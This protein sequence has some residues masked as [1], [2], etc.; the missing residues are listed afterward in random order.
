MAV[1]LL[2]N[3]TAFLVYS[4]F[5]VHAVSLSR[6]GIRNRLFAFSQFLMGLWSLAYTVMYS[7]QDHETAYVWYDL[8]A[9]G[10]VF[11]P[12]V[13]LHFYFHLAESVS[14]K[15]KNVVLVCF[16]SAAVAFIWKELTG[17][18]LLEELIY[19]DL[20][21]S[22]K[23]KEP[24]VWFISFV[25]FAFLMTITMI[26]I[27]ILNIRK[28]ERQFEKR[29]SLYVVWTMIISVLLIYIMNVLLPVIQ[30][31]E[32]LPALGSALTVMPSAITYIVL[33]KYGDLTLTP[34]M[35]IDRIMNK[36]SDG[37]ILT[38]DRNTIRFA[39]KSI[40]GMSGRKLIGSPVDT[41]LLAG[42][43]SDF[44]RRVKFQTNLSK[45]L[46]PVEIEAEP[47]YNSWKDYL[48]SV[49]TIKDIS[50]LI[51]LQEEIKNRK[52]FQHRLEATMKD[53]VHANRTRA[54]FFSRI[55]HDMRTPLNAI[56]GA[57]EMLDQSPDE[58]ARESFL[59][60]LR[61]ASK[62]LIGLIDNMLDIHRFETKNYELSYQ[63][64]EPASVI[65]DVLTIA[66]VEAER[67]NLRLN[68]RIDV[69]ELLLGDER[70]VRQILMNLLMN[71]VKFTEKGSVDLTVNYENGTLH[72]TV[73]D[74]GLGIPESML[75]E[76]YNPFTQADAS[77]TRKYGG[78]G[79][80]LAIVKEFTDRLKGSVDCRSK[81]GEF[82]TFHITLPFRTADPDQRIQETRS[83]I[84][85]QPCKVLLAEDSEDNQM[86]VSAFLKDQPVNITIAAN[87]Q[88]ALDRVNEQNFDL[89]L[90]DIQMPVMDGVMAAREIRK[91]EAETGKERTGILV[92]TAHGELEAKQQV[93]DI[94]H[95][96][97][98]HKPLKR[99]ALLEALT[100]YF[101]AK[102]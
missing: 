99:A 17:S 11:A 22:E 87:G 42:G 4:F 15:Y 86:I 1:Y 16:Y 102:P 65:E 56:L 34:V 74:T 94:D 73:Q 96:G 5:G 63:P 69:P 9:F 38:D 81:E 31:G 37:I 98:L 80:G 14:H 35:A 49:I 3:F 21:W 100:Q 89:I 72:I 54:D 70:A 8:S 79:L 57:V 12:V 93:Q 46:L 59:N 18:L 71:A 84:H 60:L 55:S 48:G 90:M 61:R 40:L 6:R 39:N 7:T 53:L 47:F 33:K 29:R 68:S 2:L 44:T 66:E 78:A 97:I 76:L 101:S 75:R 58:S 26:S 43:D 36:M 67:K 85:L 27:H 51:Q 19:V 95:D 23:L 28:T 52:A 62:T 13:F 91:F 88:E 24:D 77:I 20:F 92:F 83:K 30:P 41:M 64:F 50:G 25:S 82:T 45:N 10:W 32:E